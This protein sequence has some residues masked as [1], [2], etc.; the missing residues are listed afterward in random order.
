MSNYNNLK[1]SINN[2]IYENQ[3]QQIT[4]TVMN[5]ILNEMTNVL[6]AGYQ[7]AG[8]ATVGMNPGGPDARVFYLAG[9]GIYTNFG[10]LQVP[11]GHLGIL[12]WDSHW[13]LETI[14]GLGGGGANLTGYVSL[15]STD[16]LPDEG[17]ATLG[18]LCGTNLYLYVG[19]GGDT[20]DG[21]Y[22]NC[23]SFRGPQGI[24]GDR[25]VSVQ[26]VVQTTTSTEDEGINV[27]TVTL[28]NG[29][30]ST[31][32]VK[33]G[34]KGSQ[35]IQGPQGVQGEPGRLQAQYKQVETL[36]TASADTVD[37]IYLVESDTPNVYD[38]YYTEENQGAYSWQ[39][40]GTT[41][42]QLSD[43]A[44][45]AEVSQLEHDVP[46][47][48]GNY[49]NVTLFDT[50]NFNILGPGKFGTSTGYIHGILSVSPGEQFVLK[51]NEDA[52]SHIRYALATNSTYESGGDIPLVAD[53]EVVTLSPQ[54]TA[55]IT[56]PNGCKFLLFNTNKP[57]QDVY[58]YSLSR[59][60]GGKELEGEIANLRDSLYD[61]KPLDLSS[62]QQSGGY[63]DSATETWKN[64]DS[65]GTLHGH[66]QV[67]PGDMIKFEKRQD[68]ESNPIIYFVEEYN[69]V[70]DADAKVVGR[71]VISDEIIAQVPDSAH[72]VVYTVRLAMNS[73]TYYREPYIF[74]EELD[75]GAVV[76][77]TSVN[78]KRGWLHDWHNN[79]SG[80]TYPELYTSGCMSPIPEL[81]GKVLF[82]PKYIKAGNYVKL[83]GVPDG[84][85][86]DVFEFDSEKQLVSVKDYSGSII[87]L[88]YQTA[89][90][91]LRAYK[92]ASRSTVT[93]LQGT[94]SSSSTT[95]AIHASSAISF[96]NAD[97]YIVSSEKSG[98]RLGGNFYGSTNTYVGYKPAL[99][100]TSGDIGHLFSC[101]YVKYGFKAGTG[102]SYTA[103][104][105][106]SYILQLSVQ[107]GT[108][109]PSD[110]S[111]E[112]IVLDK[113]PNFQLAIETKNG[114]QEEFE[115]LLYNKAIVFAS[116]FSFGEWGDRETRCILRLPPNYNEKTSVPLIVFRRGNDS[117]IDFFGTNDFKQSGANYTGLVKYL[118]DEGYAVLDF[119]PNGDIF[120]Y[121]DGCGGQLNFVCM[122]SAYRRCLDAFNIEH[123]R[124]YCM[125]KSFGGQMMSQLA[126]GVCSLP[127]KAVGLLACQIDPLL[128]SFGHNKQEDDSQRV[129]SLAA[130]GVPSEDA[131]TL[132]GLFQGTGRNYFTLSSSEKQQ[133]EEILLRNKQIFY[134]HCSFDALSANK[135]FSEMLTIKRSWSKTNPDPD[136][137]DDVRRMG[138]VPVKAWQALDDEALTG[139]QSVY[140]IKTLL[141]GGSYAELRIMP[142]NTGGHH[143]VDTSSDALKKLN[144]TTALGVHYDSIALAYYE[145]VEWFRLFD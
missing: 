79:G 2:N 64:V 55:H 77:K 105:A 80:S 24:Q 69:P 37:Y 10:N 60:V 125:A 63:I 52:N 124:V 115:P 89:F 141:N 41:A 31:F 123:D 117:F 96:A 102:T 103:E 49:I 72:Y 122:E 65:T 25:G 47:L 127:V 138:R 7:F 42:V 134:P 90:V 28:E 14:E 26:S 8:V 142:N 13:H 12:K 73:A 50:A 74:T 58:H 70:E 11:Q 9:E 43:Y 17:V 137:Y 33:N 39:P 139:Y 133:Y 97:G 108:L 132:C 15:A 36:P 130:M 92:A 44:T 23:G 38:M 88:G 107:S 91:K 82:T 104:D 34:S 94:V 128:N 53:T 121:D 71:F 110:V 46:M 143:A 129:H 56:I 135:S 120:P 112:S 100:L 29:T 20:K 84:V 144:V 18:Y 86:V 1:G 126:F 32:Q 78:L 113:C 68:D 61:W 85:S 93:M 35:G 118:T 114:G 66:I 59:V 54:E 95:N 101:E 83:H 4:G 22:Q 57:E 119:H 48:A 27:I 116:P 5:T 16:D 136:L 140:Y 145:L 109:A 67:S 21:K 45:K 76:T 30:Q 98:L 87:S 51:S 40:L 62:V 6:G 131:S 106:D 19:E 99:G 81:D 3:T 75:S 111:V